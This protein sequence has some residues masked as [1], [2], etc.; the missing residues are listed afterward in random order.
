MWYWSKNSI[1]STSVLFKLLDIICLQYDK[2]LFSVKY[3]VINFLNSASLWVKSFMKI[4]VSIVK[5]LTKDIIKDSNTVLLICLSFLTSILNLFASL[6][7]LYALVFISLLR[8]SSLFGIWTE[9]KRKSWSRWRNLKLDQLGL[10]R[11]WWLIWWLLINSRA[12]IPF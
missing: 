12:I 3:L 8:R 7:K 1:T 9:K 4:I 10:R 2:I 5:N 6:I 11:A